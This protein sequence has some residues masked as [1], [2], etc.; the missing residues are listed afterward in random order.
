MPKTT[1]KSKSKS[2]STTKSTTKS[3]S[4]S[5]P[6]AHQPGDYVL[7]STTT[8]PWTIVAGTLVEERHDGVVTLREA[9]MIVYYAVDAKGLLGVAVRGPGTG[10]RVTAAVDLWVGRAI[11]QILSVT[12]AARAAIEAEPWA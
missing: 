1:S 8:R 2:K 11:E 5:T 6:R 10:A 4:K 9:R 3:T 7:L 12:P